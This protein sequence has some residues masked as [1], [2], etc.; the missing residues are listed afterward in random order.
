MDGLV[1]ER[2]EVERVPLIE[3]PSPLVVK[4]PATSHHTARRL[5]NDAGGNERNEL[6]V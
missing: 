2:R 5:T 6:L 1:R 3:Y 4:R